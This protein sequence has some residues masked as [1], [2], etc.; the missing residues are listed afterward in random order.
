MEKYYDFLAEFF[1]EAKFCA[2]FVEKNGT[3]R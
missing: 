3:T 2:I 1:E